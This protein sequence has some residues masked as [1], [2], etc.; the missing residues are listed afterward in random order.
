MRRQNERERKPKKE[1][2]TRMKQKYEQM[3]EKR[4]WQGKRSGKMT[5]NA[6]TNDEIA[7]TSRA[8]ILNWEHDREC[9]KGKHFSVAFYSVYFTLSSVRTVD[10][11]VDVK[12]VRK[13]RPYWRHKTLADTHENNKKKLETK[14]KSQRMNATNKRATNERQKKKKKCE[15]RKWKLK[16]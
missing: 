12:W 16:H 11:S 1:K 6:T 14:M 7:K 15:K 8:M 9:Q 4:R 5:K 13:C 10:N 2:R 3:K